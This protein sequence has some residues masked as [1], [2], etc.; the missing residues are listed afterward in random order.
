MIDAEISFFPPILNAFDPF[1]RS[2]LSPQVYSAGQKQ[3]VQRIVKSAPSSETKLSA[4]DQKIAALTR[5]GDL[6]ITRKQM[7]TN[8]VS[9]KEL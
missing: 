3:T 2:S 7:P 8:T 9:R 1:Q 4:Q 6:K 5:H